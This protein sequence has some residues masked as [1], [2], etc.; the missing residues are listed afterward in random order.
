[1]PQVNAMKLRAG[2]VERVAALC[3]GVDGH[4]GVGMEAPGSEW[5]G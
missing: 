5:T 3:S 2:Q 4:Q 1:M